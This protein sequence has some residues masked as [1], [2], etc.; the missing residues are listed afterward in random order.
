[1]KLLMR[2]FAKLL[3]GLLLMEAL[4]FGPAGTWHFPGAW[5]LL[6]LLFVPMPVVGAVLYRRAPELGSAAA[7]LPFLFVPA[8]LVKRIRNEEQVLE[9]GLPGYR[10]Y[11]KKVKYRMVP[12]LW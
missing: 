4:L 9:A 5:R 11:E 2:A 12:F 8:V 6:A 7:L 3:S 10:A 1:M